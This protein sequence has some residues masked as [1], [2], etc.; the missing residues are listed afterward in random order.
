MVLYT[1]DY[2]EKKNCFSLYFSAL[3]LELFQNHICCLLTLSGY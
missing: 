1:L 3:Y 2:K